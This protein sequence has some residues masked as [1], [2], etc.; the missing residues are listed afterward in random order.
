LYNMMAMAPR[1]RPTRARSGAAP[2]RRAKKA[3]RAQTAELRKFLDEVGAPELTDEEYA[4]LM[5]EH[6]G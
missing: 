2:K 4:R 1:P 5:A 6:N 3:T